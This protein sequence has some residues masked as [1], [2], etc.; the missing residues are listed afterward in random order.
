MCRSVFSVLILMALSRVT[1][2]PNYA[3]AHFNIGK[4]YERAGD[5][6]AAV[7]HLRTYKELTKS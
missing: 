2:D 4:L 1:V 7:R 3:E 6:L 5:D